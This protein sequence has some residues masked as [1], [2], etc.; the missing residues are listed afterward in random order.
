METGSPSANLSR[1]E[2]PANVS[3][4]G[5]GVDIASQPTA[6]PIG[7]AMQAQ[8][9]KH[10]LQRWILSIGVVNFDLEK[11]PDLERLWPPLDISREEKDNM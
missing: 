10:L 11:G 8:T 7:T 4:N 5:Q 2:V 1:Q 9:D 3:G 6:V